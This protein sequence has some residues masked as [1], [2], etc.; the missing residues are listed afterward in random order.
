MWILVDNFE[1]GLEQWTHIDVEN[2]TDPFVQ[3]PQI[4]EIRSEAQT[5]NHFMLR[6]PA[7]DGIVGNRKAIG[8]RPLPV[9]SA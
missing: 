1:S 8:F 3:N 2:N 9:F 7:A 4:A 6:K 5:G